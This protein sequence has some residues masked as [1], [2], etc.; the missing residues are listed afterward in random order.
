MSLSHLFPREEYRVEELGP[1][2]NWCLL[3]GLLVD[4]NPAASLW[5]GFYLKVKLATYSKWLG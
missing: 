1:S 4:T 3:K 2:S 5:K